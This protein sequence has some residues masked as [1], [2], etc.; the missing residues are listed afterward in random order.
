MGTRAHPDE[1]QVPYFVTFATYGRHPVFQ[2]LETARLLVD[3]LHILRQELRFLLLSYVV[4]P[5]HVHLVVV[6]SSVA[7]LAKIM[8]YVKGRF[9]R[10]YH[11]RNGGS[12]R[13]W[14][15]RYYE[16]AV[17]DEAALWRRI[18]YIE[19]NPMKAG[20]V[21]QPQ[22]YPFSSAAKERMDLEKYLAPGQEVPA[23]SPG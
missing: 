9:A 15:S 6:P 7:G 5:D 10:L 12:G 22:D 19:E 3:E 23:S 17:R 18:E 20:L 2:D 8:Q 11:V 13:L 1:P 4:M 14:Q 21:E 16:T